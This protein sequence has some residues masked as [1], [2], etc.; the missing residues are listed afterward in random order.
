MA[1]LRRRGLLGWSAG[2]CL[3]VSRPERSAPARSLPLTA[4]RQAAREGRGGAGSISRSAC[5]TRAAPSAT[6]LRREDVRS[7]TLTG[8]GSDDVFGTFGRG[9]EPADPGAAA[10]GRA[11]HRPARFREARRQRRA[12][13]RAGRQGRSPPTS[14]PSRPA[15]PSATTPATRMVAAMG[16]IGKV[17]E[18]WMSDPARMA[19]AQAA[20]ATPFLQLWAQTYRRMQGETVEP[21]VPLAK[22]DKRFAAPEWASLPLF[23]F[24]RQAHALGA[25]WADALVDGAVRRRS[26]QPAPRRA[27]TCAR[28]RPRPRRPTFLATNPE[29]M[30]S[31]FESSGENLVRGAALLAE[32]MERGGGTLRLRQTD[33]RGLRSRTQRSGVAGQGRVPQR[34]VRADPVQPDDARGAEAPAADRAAVDQQVLHPRSQQGE[35]LRRLGGE[36]GRDRVPR[37]VGQPGRAPP[38]HAVR[39][40]HARGHLRR[41]R[42]G[43]AGD[44]RKRGQRHRLLHRR[45]A[46]GGDA[47]LHGRAR[48]PAHRRARPSSRRRPTSAT[49]ANSA[50]SSTTPS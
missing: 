31:T 6:V 50:S 37:L 45:H 47:G 7:G 3:G 46:A 13:S 25:N 17:A 10:D 34:A 48:R 49:P 1:L 22:G 32:D 5:W 20:I 36:P 28:S 41:P 27:S 38:R 19:E 40:L 33:H 44:R 11:A 2:G 39:G 42:R 8:A 24:L 23:D 9:E 14:S 43:R 30:R 26:P 12:L 35:E 29:L 4:R 16:A 18:H 15:R 21:L